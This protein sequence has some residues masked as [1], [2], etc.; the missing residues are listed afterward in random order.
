MPTFAEQGLP[1]YEAST[2]NN[3]FAPAKT[4]NDVIEKL[5]AALNKALA[6]PGVQQRMA[7]G[8]S[9]AIGPSTPEQADAHGRSQRA[10]GARRAR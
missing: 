10:M 7:Q 6:N 4:P 5:N 9:D 1:N 8:A 3:L 2:W